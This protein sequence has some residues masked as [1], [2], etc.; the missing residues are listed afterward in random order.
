MGIENKVNYQRFIKPLAFLHY[1]LKQMAVF[2]IEPKMIDNKMLNVMIHERERCPVYVRNL[3]AT[4]VAMQSEVRIKMRILNKYY[5]KLLEPM[6]VCKECEKVIA[7]AFVCQQLFVKCK[8]IEIEME[9]SM[10][11]KVEQLTSLFVETFVAEMEKVNATE[12]MLNEV[13]IYQIEIDD[14]LKKQMEDGL[15]GWKMQMIESPKDK[16][17][18][19]KHLSIARID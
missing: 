3:F 19:G 16:K 14:T 7:I 11:G 9:A 1:F 8:R 10:N 15:K 5:G 13:C 2:Y 18:V 17:Y 4:F 12:C 6:F